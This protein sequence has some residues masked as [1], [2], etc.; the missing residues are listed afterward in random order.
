MGLAKTNYTPT[1]LSQLL[2]V[3]SSLLALILLATSVPAI[4]FAASGTVSLIGG[5]RIGKQQAVL[6]GATALSVAILLASVSG[7][8]PIPLLIATV[9]NVLAWDSGERA[10]TLGEQLGGKASTQEIEVMHSATT[11]GVL[12][13]AA[14]GSYIVFRITTG[15]QPAL[16]LVTLL[17]A[18]L[19]LIVALE[20]LR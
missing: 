2:A 20:R 6:L 3:G 12:T 13:A 10:I 4:L 15:A 19:L 11:G 9:A 8:Q 17:I 18:A 16:A 7:A 14:L 1:R 5:I